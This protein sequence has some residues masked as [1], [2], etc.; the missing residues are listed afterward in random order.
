M[1][2]ARIIQK[3]IPRPRKAIREKAK[4]ARLARITTRRLIAAEVRVLLKY[5]R[6]RLLVPRVVI[7]ASRVKCEANQ[8]TGMAVV[9]LSGFSAVSMAQRIGINQNIAS[10]T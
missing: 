9:S 7:N 4:A 2:P 10:T 5:Q 3:R 6:G 8:D 1:I